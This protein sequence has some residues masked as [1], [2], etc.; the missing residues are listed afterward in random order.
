MLLCVLF[1]SLLEA[2]QVVLCCRQL[3]KQL[4]WSETRAKLFRFG[5]L[6]GQAVDIVLE[7]AAGMIVGI[8]CKAGSTIF[9]F[10]D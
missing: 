7:A 2:S 9:S 3:N 1:S 8:Q 4:A 5:I 10:N 6:N